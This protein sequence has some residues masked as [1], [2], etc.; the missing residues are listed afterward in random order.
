MVVDELHAKVAPHKVAVVASSFGMQRS[1][2]RALGKLGGDGMDLCVANLGVACTQGR[3][4]KT[5]RGQSQ[6]HKRFAKALPKAGK[7]ARLAKGSHKAA[8]GVFKQ[9]LLPSVGY[10]S[11]V[12]GMPPNLLAKMRSW[13][14]SF[15]AGR[16]KGKDHTKILALKGDPTSH[17]ALAPLATFVDLLW[18]AGMGIKGMPSYG[19]LALWW[20][21]TPSAPKRWCDTKGPIAATRWAMK[22]IGWESRENTPLVFHTAAGKRL[23]VI[24]MGPKLVKARMTQD[25][26]DGLAAKIAKKV[27]L[28]SGERIDF[29]HTYVSAA[30]PLNDH[31]RATADNFVVGGAWD[32]A[33]LLR[34]GY[35]LDPDQQLCQ[36]CHKAFDSI[37]HRLLHC[38]CPAVDELRDEHLPGHLAL[39]LA[40]KV[41]ANKHRIDQKMRIREDQARMLAK[42]GLARDPSIAQP[43]PA[44]EGE[45]DTSA[46]RDGWDFELAGH[47]LFNDGACTRPFH[48]SLARAAWATT[49]V[50]RE[51]EVIAACSG[52]VWAHLPQTAP[53]SEVVAAAASTQVAAKASRCV[54]IVGDNASVVNTM[55]SRPHPMALAKMQYAGIWRSI[56]VHDGWSK[57][58]EVEHVRSHQ[59]DKWPGL[60]GPHSD[61]TEEQKLAIMG[62]DQADK[63]AEAAQSW[64]P[65]MEMEA[66]KIDEWA[67]KAARAVYYLAAKIMPLHPKRPRHSKATTP[68]DTSASASPPHPTLPSSSETRAGLED[69]DDDAEPAVQTDQVQDHMNDGLVFRPMHLCQAPSEFKKQLKDAKADDPTSTSHDKPTKPPSAQHQWQEIHAKPGTWRCTTCGLVA[70]TGHLHQPSLG[71]CFGRSRV[72]EHIGAGH[73][74]V[75]YRAHPNAPECMDAFACTV[76]H[77]TATTQPVFDE[78][79]DGMPTKSRT[80]G[81]QRVEKGLHPHP[82]WGQKPF[83]RA[84]VALG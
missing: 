46:G 43:P 83:F 19:D 60:L 39:W 14:C 11:Q 31:E 22:L 7:I 54:K 24:D 74:I 6:V 53:S 66:F 76:C 10:G 26:Q 4:I 55:A 81:F 42:Q 56:I 23:N 35:Q 21:S 45:E 62:N 80:R 61:L 47:T 28:P 5:A 84:G 58:G 77:K 41:S 8:D 25:W 33:R 75:H 57:V 50:N 52:P 71:G 18:A 17:L 29:H 40:G 73:R 15:I 2:A 36:L 51:G 72:V 63:Q 69:A 44:E 27:G 67:Y 48:P 30:H 64:H 32:A 38:H 34:A 37:E 70:N 49:M 12:W 59:L 13:F 82:R 1:I 78:A 68:A 20:R 79:C 16:A 3:A 65:P 9:G